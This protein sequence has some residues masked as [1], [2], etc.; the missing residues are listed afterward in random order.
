MKVR[1]RQM[2]CCVDPI[3]AQ[4]SNSRPRWLCFPSNLQLSLLKGKTQLI[5]VIIGSWAV[6]LEKPARLLALLAGVDIL[7]LI[8]LK[9]YLKYY[10]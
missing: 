3:T 8:Y 2:I 1:W 7:L 5:Q 6:F 9:V 4:V 10:T